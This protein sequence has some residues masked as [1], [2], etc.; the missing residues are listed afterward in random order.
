MGVLSCYCD[1]VNDK[2]AVKYW[3]FNQFPTKIYQQMHGHKAVSFGQQQQ[4]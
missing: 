2:D 1:I 3:L 4:L